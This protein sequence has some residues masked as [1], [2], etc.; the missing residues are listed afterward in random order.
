M[1]GVQQ[2]KRMMGF[3]S[4]MCSAALCV[5]VLSLSE[6]PAFAQSGVPRASAQPSGN[7]EG[8]NTQKTEE[9]AEA[10]A[11]LNGPAGNAECVWT[12]RQVVKQLWNDDLDLAFRH[13]DLYDRFGCPPA[14]IQ[15][16]FRCLIQQGP[17]DGNKPEDTIN[18][19]AQA[20]WIKP[21]PADPQAAPAPTTGNPARR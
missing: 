21:A 11:A 20:C 16:A 2:A 5:A 13:L 15:A 6:L 12:G 7:P 17:F 19:R 10:A 3:L 9:L 4:R 1:G 8:K 18:A 14:H